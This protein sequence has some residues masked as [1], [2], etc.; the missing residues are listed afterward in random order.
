MQYLPHPSRNAN[1]SNSFLRR[2]LFPTANPQTL[3][4]SMEDADT[5]FLH[6][7][8]AP[9]LVEQSGY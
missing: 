5:P 7:L 3:N 1:V 4:I 8:K 9:S 2:I 6:L